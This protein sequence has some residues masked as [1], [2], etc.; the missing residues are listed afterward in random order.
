VSERGGFHQYG[1]PRRVE[2]GLRARSARGA[3]GES[4]WSR[5]F[6]EVLESSALGS[7]LTRGRSYAR[8]GQVLSLAVRPGVATASVQGSRA[9]PY[10]VTIGLAPVPESVWDRVEQALAGQAVHCARLLA[11]EVPTDLVEAFDAAG[12]A[13][14]PTGV[15][16]LALRCDCPDPQVP[17]KHVAATCYLLAE[18][19]DT[20][21]F[22]LLHWRGRD[23]AALLSRL[24]ELRDAATPPAPRR[25][26]GHRRQPYR[27]TDDRSGVPEPDAVSPWDAGRALADLPSTP[28]AEMVDRFWD[29]PVAPPARR[30]ALPVEADLLLRQLPPPGEEIGGARLLAA[31]RVAYARFGGRD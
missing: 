3:I 18:S 6:L 26:F 9:R 27:A 4:W 23:R 5:R 20:D 8:A 2:G 15:A 21:P 14:F 30:P 12:A 22:A 28:L 10:T 25:R 19:F 29:M 1:P 11:G 24:R 31:L 17:C 13:L 7:R 16:E